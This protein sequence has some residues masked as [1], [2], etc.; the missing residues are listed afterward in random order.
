MM[1]QAEPKHNALT[2]QENIIRHRQTI[3]VSCAEPEFEYGTSPA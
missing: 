1:L 2:S 3:I